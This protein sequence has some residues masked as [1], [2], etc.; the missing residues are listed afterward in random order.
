MK[1]QEIIKTSIMAVFIFTLFLFIGLNNR[2]YDYAE[3]VYQVYLNGNKLGT[4]KNQE[5]LYALINEEQK[6]I[7]ETYEVSNVYPP[8]GFEI[9][10]FDT[11]NDNVTTARQIYDK[12]KTAGDFTIEGYIV[13]IKPSDKEK[14]EITLYVLNKEIF[15]TAIENVVTAFVD[16]EDFKKYINNEQEKIEDV[17]EIIE[18]MY[19]EETITMKPAHISVNNKIYKDPLE[20]TQYLLFGSSKEQSSYTVKAGDTIASISEAN[21]LN[22]QE[23][24]IANPKYTSENSIL[25]I[26]DKVNITLIKPVLTLVEDLH[27]VKDEEQSYDK[28]VVYDKSKPKTFSEVTQAG[29]TGIVRITRKIQVVNGEQNQGVDKLSDVTIRETVN[30]ITTKGGTKPSSGHGGGGGGGSITGGFWETGLDWGWP[31]NRPYV[32]TSRYEWRWGSFH[33]ALDISGT[34]F[35]SPIYAAKDGIVVEM[36][37][38]CPNN[39]Y[40]SSQCGGTYGNYVVIQHENNVYTMYAHMVKNVNVGVGS[41]VT[42]GQILGGMG[43]SGSSTGAHLHFGVSIGVPNQ[44]GSR[45]INPYSLYK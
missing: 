6:D 1:K 15:E 42:R 8:N 34:G 43:N 19:F 35:G 16:E 18:K 30:E 29:V 32:I 26:G 21:K 27:V 2:N 20:L 14:K 41:T 22:P 40:Y 5:E 45:W 39:G 23:F 28:E 25:G 44:P 3:K 36:N 38:N 31:T 33:N 17:G 13:K 4:L 12:I 7:R 24:L 9:E 10:E 11:Y 37:N